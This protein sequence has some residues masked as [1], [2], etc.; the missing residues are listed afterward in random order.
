MINNEETAQ[1]ILNI[2][3][4]CGADINDSIL[5]VQDNCSNDEFEAYRNAMSKVMSEIL[6]EGLNPIFNQH[7]QLK[8]KGFN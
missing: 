5:Y 6:F 1:H 7:P 3:L 2:L 4:R 8:P